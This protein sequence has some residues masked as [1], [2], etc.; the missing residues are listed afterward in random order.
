MKWLLYVS[1]LC[2]LFSCSQNKNANPHVIIQTNSGDIEVELYINN[3]PKTVNAFLQF[4]DA[5]VYKNRSFYRV[6]LEEAA[7]PEANTG[8]IQGGTWPSDN[9]QFASVKNIEHE[10]TNITK[11]SHTTG[12]ISL[13][14]TTVGT[15][16]TEFFICIGNQT[17][18]DFGSKTP[19]DG[20]G[21]AAFGKVV[22]GMLLVR[23]IQTNSANGE[24]FTEKIV[25]NNIKRK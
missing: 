18:F 10:A 3:A 11:L 21:M 12:T 22:K 24:L 8:L 1:F 19:P 25:I 7:T 9:K 23:K 2:V 20:L 17:H 14:R 4:I 15:A 5:G 16:S 6:I 13:A